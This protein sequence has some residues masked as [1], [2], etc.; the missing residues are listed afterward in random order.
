MPCLT[1]ERLIGEQEK[2]TSQAI[3]IVLILASFTCSYQKKKKVVG[4]SIYCC[5]PAYEA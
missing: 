5:V 4:R 1:G 2:D 3:H